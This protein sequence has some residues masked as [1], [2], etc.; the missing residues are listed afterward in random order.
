MVVA[1]LLSWDRL[2]EEGL[3][4]AA[5]EES[6]M[7]ESDAVL[8]ILLRCESLNSDLSAR[9]RDDSIDSSLSLTGL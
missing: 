6:V 7:V 8:A 5:K 2:E 3:G 9:L 4:A 1:A